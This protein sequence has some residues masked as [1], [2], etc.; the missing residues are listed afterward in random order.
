LAHGLLLLGSALIWLLIAPPTPIYNAIQSRPAALSMVTVFQRVWRL[1]VVMG[2]GGGI[3]FTVGAWLPPHLIWT[4]GLSPI[5]AGAFSSVLL[6]TGGAGRVLGGV[7][8]AVGFWREFTAICTGLSLS[9]VGLV[10]FGWPG[11]PLAPA[12]LALILIGSGTSVG[13]TAVL[14]LTSQRCPEAPGAA[15]GIVA[16]LATMIAVMGSS[17]FGMLRDLTQTSSTAF[18]T[19]AGGCLGVMLLVRPLLVMSGG[20]LEDVPLSKV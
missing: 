20:R 8:Q 2:A 19:F 11:L 3:A 1:G 5:M 9:V 13:F 18:I 6:L 12:V 15:Q 4:Y 17:M 14:S 10:L 16:V 7:L